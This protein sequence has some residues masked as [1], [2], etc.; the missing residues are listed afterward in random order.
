MCCP[1]LA[2][3]ECPINWRKW[4]RRIV[5]TTSTDIN[6]QT[7]TVSKEMDASDLSETE[8]EAVLAADEGLNERIANAIFN[9]YQIQSVFYPWRVD[10]KIRLWCRISAQV[11]N[12][13]QEYRKLGLAVL[14][15]K[16][17]TN[18]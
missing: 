9:G 15:L 16:Q 8:A 10:N 14:D 12:T 3:I 13:P 17:R 5:T 2:T 6:G 7:V 18:S 4:V 1:I 11:Y